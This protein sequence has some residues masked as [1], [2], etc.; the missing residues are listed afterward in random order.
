MFGLTRT[1]KIAAAIVIAIV[2]FFGTL[3]AL[4]LLTPTVEPQRPVLAETPA[5]P[6]ATRP[7][8][9]I[10]PVAIA[11]P[12]IRQ[13]MENAAPRSL[14]GRPDNPIAKVLSKA[15]VGYTLE[16]APLTLTGRA[17]GL[18]VAAD[19]NGTLRVTGQLPAQLNSLIGVLT[20]EKTQQERNGTDPTKDA[21]KNAAKNAV[22]NGR[23]VDLHADLKGRVT[24]TSR[25]KITT[26]WRLEA[27]LSGKTDLAEANLQVAGV[28]F[29]GAREI[30]SLVDRA[31]SDQMLALAARVRDDLFIENAARREWIKICRSIPLESTAAGVPPLWLETKPVRAFASQP[32]VDA[33]NVTITLGMQAETR[34]VPQQTKPDCPF[35]TK[36]DLVPPMDQ[37]KIAIGVP[38]DV[39]FAELNRLID[40]QLTGKTFP[41]DGSGAAQITVLRAVAATA[42]DRVVV[43]MLVKA[44]ERKSWFGFG[45]EA[46]IHV[47][48][49]PALDQERQTLRLDDIALAV[50]SDAAFGLLGVAAKAAI[51]A[52]QNALARS[53]VIDLRPALANARKSID[54]A[55]ADFRQQGDGIKTDAQLTGLRLVGIEFDSQIVRVTAEIDGIARAAVSRLPGK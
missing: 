53:S 44:Q 22:K 40:T 37:G 52:L 6:P 11:I 32:R 36:L 31:M 14:S 30:R 16:R 45:S 8:V 13:A 48:G 17:D 12:A 28:K 49:K 1:L 7:S 3:W 39:P 25:P 4:N 23:P 33:N 46:T 9:I 19:L 15:E 21:A 27:N 24:I 20:G 35:P 10:A 34:I 54:K 55:L 51:P 50:E 47:S 38:I 42:G 41:E 43:S 18:I 26:G 5:L 2:F 29:N